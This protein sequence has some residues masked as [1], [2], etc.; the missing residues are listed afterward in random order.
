[1][2]ILTL[3]RKNILAKPLNTLMSILLFALSIGLIT[4]LT[5]FNHQFK[6]GLDNNLAGIDLVIGAKGSPLQLI[7]SSMYHID[8]PTGNIPLSEAAPFLNPKHPLITASVPLSLGDSYGAYRI[9]GA[10][11]SILMMYGAKQVEGDIY[12][13][14]FDVVVGSAVARQQHLHIGDDFFSTHGLEENED[15]MHDHGAPFLVTGILQPTGT[16]LD[17][18]ILCTPQTVW[19]VH[20]HDST[21]VESHEGHGHEHHDHSDGADQHVQMPVVLIDTNEI[22][23]LSDTIM[24]QLR[25]QSEKEITSILLRYK[26]R[27]NIQALNM[28]RNINANTG[29]MAASPAL[30][31][32]R[33]YS[34]MGSGTDALGYLAFLIAIVA[35]VSIFISLYTSL[36]ERRYEMALMRV[37]GAGPGKL[38]TMIIAEGLWIALIGLIIGLAMGHAGMTF[39]G[40]L[41]EQ[42]YKYQFTGLIWVPE[43]IWIIVGALV[44]GV[45]ASVIPAIQGARTELHKTLSE[46]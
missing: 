32:N 34:M 38:F 19:K 6:R 37:S 46:G 31:I 28:L 5:L 14:D 4:F 25:A 40:G 16:V 33:L 29:L 42:G 26:S 43:E 13:H 12:H 23:V 30:E 44:I 39:A 15:L 41:L 1:M 3:S 17:Q 8:A 20:E 7:L 36:K 24:S 22:K 10:P 21:S 35:A 9:V 2:N 27:T 45:M 11:Q 18:L